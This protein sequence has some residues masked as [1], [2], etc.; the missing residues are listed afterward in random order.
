[1]M[2]FSLLKVDK[3][4]C[5]K[6][7]PNAKVV[8][9]IKSPCKTNRMIKFDDNTWMYIETSLSGGNGFLMHQK[10]FIEQDLFLNVLNKYVDKQGRIIY[11]FNCIDIKDSVLN[12][13]M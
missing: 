6:Y 10:S 9:Y 13:H 1:M 5:K 2:N 12:K 8:T 7:K 3:D 11:L 4:I